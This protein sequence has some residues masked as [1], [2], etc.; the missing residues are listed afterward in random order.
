MKKINP[1]SRLDQAQKAWI[2][3]FFLVLVLALK[4]FFIKLPFFWDEPSYVDNTL[5]VLK[6]HFN[7]FI[8]KVYSYRPPL[9]FMLTA[10][11]YKI[12]GF[13]IV[14]S[15][16]LIPV[17]GLIAVW[18][19][20]LTTERLYGKEAGLW[21]GLLLFFSP[22]FFAQSGLLLESIPVTALT[23][24]TIYFY[25][26][27]KKLLYLVSAAL[28]ALTREIGVI[29]IIA[30]IGYQFLLDLAVLADPKNK[31]PLFKKI[32]GLGLKSLFYVLP[33]FFF[34][35]WLLFNKI[36]LGFFLWPMNALIVTHN[37]FAPQYIGL[38]LANAFCLHYRCLV[39][40]AIMLALVA[41]LFNK[42]LRGRF[43]NKEFLLFFMVTFL[44]TFFYMWVEG[45]RETYGTFAV[46]PRYYLLLQVL[47]FIFG[48][49]A[50]CALFKNK[51][52]RRIVFVLLIY[53]FIRSWYAPDYKWAGE[54]NLSY[55]DI[56][57]AHKEAAEFLEANYYN[58]PV[59]T[60]WPLYRELKEPRWG[61]VV[62]GLAEVHDI[63]HEAGGKLDRLIAKI[64]AAASN[65]SIIVVIPANGVPNEDLIKLRDNGKFL[66]KEI[67]EG[68]ERVWIY[69]LPGQ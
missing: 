21:A 9:I 26:S 30:V 52:A 45:T 63:N 51:P 23:A 62:N 60:T 14:S 44:V 61:Y 1:D 15:R 39:L 28:L 35:A 4:A 47:F 12:F 54:R 27:G 20:F 13:S 59:I 65:A 68:I 24:S 2:F 38:I 40:L 49:G 16:F 67:N 32:R 69:R 42:N 31:Q 41:G 18:C 3:L 64:R 46:L 50:I 11:M 6:N 34:L 25:I 8:G 37:G 53:L 22:I 56:I 43:L 10:S 48:S 57:S 66:I 5:A 55:R 58:S 29:V 19:T 33:L 7:P 17:F 36:F